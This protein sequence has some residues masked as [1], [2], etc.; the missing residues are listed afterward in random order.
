MR[1]WMMSS[2][3]CSLE[4]SRRCGRPLTNGALCCVERRALGA[5][6]CSLPLVIERVADDLRRLL[7]L[8]TRHIEMRNET[9]TVLV[10]RQGQHLTLAH[11]PLQTRGVETRLS[12]VELQEENIGF[13]LLR[14]EAQTACTAD[15]FGEQL[16][17]LVVLSQA[18]D[19]VLQGVETTHC[20]DP[21]LAHAATEHFAVAVRPADEVS[22][23]RQH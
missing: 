7:D 12:R 17:M 3:R 15:A 11:G 5:S 8:R 9:H 22:T 2:S 4:S 18:L 10:H 16:G 14:I 6:L 20:D 21:S 1:R 19:V 13:H 23:T